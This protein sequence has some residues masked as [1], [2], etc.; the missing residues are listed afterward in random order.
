MYANDDFAVRRY[1][2]FGVP[3]AELATIRASWERE[4]RRA[5][6]SLPDIGFDPAPPDVANGITHARTPNGPA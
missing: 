4:L 2:R 5:I 6:Q 1:R 3:D